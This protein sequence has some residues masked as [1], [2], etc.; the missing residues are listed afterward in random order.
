MSSSK[1]LKAR[2][3]GLQGLLDPPGP[4]VD[5][6]PTSLGC[7]SPGPASGLGSEIRALKSSGLSH[8]SL[9]LAPCTPLLC[10][11][12]LCLCLRCSLPGHQAKDSPFFTTQLTA[13]LSCSLQSWHPPSVWFPN[14]DMSYKS[15]YISIPCP[16]AWH[17]AQQLEDTQQ[18]AVDGGPA[19]TL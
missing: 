6:A 9:F 1:W 5:M 12:Q 13:L 16:H 4:A 11:P 15:F 7:E 17:M 18:M 3:Q 14:S 2:P 19:C 8:A 10:L